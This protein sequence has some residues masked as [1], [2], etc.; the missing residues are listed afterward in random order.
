[1]GK[2]PVRFP[3]YSMGCDLSKHADN[4]AS[5]VGSG[6]SLSRTGYYWTVS[7]GGTILS[8]NITITKKCL[9]VVVAFFVC[10]SSTKIS[11]IKR[12]GVTKTAG[13]TIS[14]INFALNGLYGHLQYACEVLDAGTYTFDLVAT[15]GF[16]C[17]GAMMKLV[18][19][20]A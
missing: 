10:G 2:A 11:D 8:Q 19:V 16:D 14:S 5:N 6:Q 9:I 18:A 7:I 3:N 4:Q 15:S 13:T 20:T 12:G 17:Y 1:M